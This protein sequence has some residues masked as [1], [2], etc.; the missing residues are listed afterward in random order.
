MSW[1]D[2]LVISLTALQLAGNADIMRQALVYG[3]RTARTNHV[4]E[5]ALREAEAA[6]NL[7]MTVDLLTQAWD[8]Q[9]Y[10]AGALRTANRYDWE[11]A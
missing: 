4:L 6:G 3:L 9:S 2:N 8:G 10:I 5:N 7:C 11:V 1:L